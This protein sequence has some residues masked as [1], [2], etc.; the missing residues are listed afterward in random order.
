MNPSKFESLVDWVMENK[1][2][3]AILIYLGHTWLVKSLKEKGDKITHGNL[4]AVSNVISERQ[5]V[6][7]RQNFDKYY[8]SALYLFRPPKFAT[9]KPTFSYDDRDRF[10]YLKNKLVGRGSMGKVFK[11]K[12][13]PDYIDQKLVD[14]YTLWSPKSK[15]R[16]LFS[17][18]ES[19]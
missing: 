7:L 9:G 10:P 12:I 16:S 15:A 19:I 6:G 3:L 13:H 5:F 8:K 17:C 1:I 11:V 2:L 18:I 14:I 4:D